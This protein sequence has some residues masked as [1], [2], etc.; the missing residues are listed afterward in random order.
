M[1]GFLAVLLLPV[2]ALLAGCGPAAVP[3]DLPSLD[4]VM[5]ALEDATDGSQTQQGIFAA[6]VQPGTPSVLAGETTDGYTGA[7]QVACSSEGGSSLTV[8]VEIDGVDQG[9]ITAQCGDAPG[10]TVVSQ[11]AT[12]YEFAGGFAFTVEPSVP[13]VVALGVVTD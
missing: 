1:R 12:T 6:A 7:V 13:A 3:A 4:A 9:T 8:T 11:L 2:V 10:A 5:G